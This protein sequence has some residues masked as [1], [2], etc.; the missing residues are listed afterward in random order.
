MEDS[1]ILAKL[2]A[3]LRREVRGFLDKCDEEKV[4]DLWVMRNVLRFTGCEIDEISREQLI[5]RI[6]RLL[7][8]QIRWSRTRHPRYDLNRHIS[9]RRLRRALE[10]S[11][12]PTASTKKPAKETCA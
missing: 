10:M 6:S 3:N 8:A 12:P 2:E 7:A 1:H 5:E 11:T 4:D 9:L